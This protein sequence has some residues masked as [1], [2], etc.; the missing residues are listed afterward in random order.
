[1]REVVQVVSRACVN[2]KVGW[3]GPFTN[4]LP[5]TPGRMRITTQQFDRMVADHWRQRVDRALHK[6]VPEYRTASQ[7]LR[8]DFLT[9]AI[10]DA[11]RAG[12]AT[13]QGV[14][15]YVLG[16]WYLEPGFE[17]RSRLL[18]ALFNSG[19]PEF[20]RL[21]AMNAWVRATIGKPADPAGAD[22]ALRKAFDMTH[23]WGRGAAGRG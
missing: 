7:A 22:D 4:A 10:D 19:I 15:G 21:H 16:A 17:D 11:G 1:M 18:A 8:D 14:A 6:A 5:D 2:L 9:L 23:A 12:F 20:R 13:E 3:Y